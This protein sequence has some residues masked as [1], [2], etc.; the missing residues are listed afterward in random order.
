LRL[1]VSY[2]GGAIVYVNGQEV[3]RE[4]LPAGEVGPLDLAADYPAEAL[5]IPG[6]EQPLPR[7]SRPAEEYRDRYEKRIRRLAVSIPPDVLRRGPDVLA[8]ELHCSATRRGQWN[9]VGLCEVRLTSRTGN[10]VIAYEDAAGGLQ[11][12]NASPL[13][14]ISP[15]TDGKMPYRATWNV[16]PLAVS[17]GGIKYGNPFDPLRPMRMVAARGGVCSGQVVLSSSSGLHK[18]R[19]EIGPL[20]HRSGAIIPSEDVAIRYAHQAEGGRYCDAFLPAPAEDVTVQPVWVIVDI[21]NRQPSGWYTGKLKVAAEGTTFD[22]PVQ[23]LVSGWELPDPR[24]CLSFASLLNS[25]DGVALQYDVEPLSPEH[26]AL[27]GESLK[28]MGQV[29]QVPRRAGQDAGADR[30]DPARPGHG[31]DDQVGGPHVWMRRQPGLLEADDRRRS[32]HRAG[33]RLG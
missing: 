28:L 20:T 32:P 6:G 29:G 12:S 7:A 3:A 9:T 17:P 4:H 27:L 2:R 33:S 22:V 5:F 15:T 23:V 8:I 14:T 26:F 31:Q 16:G 11:L 19:A 21:P 18:V 13:A 30:R 1:E 25:P 10:G 24:D